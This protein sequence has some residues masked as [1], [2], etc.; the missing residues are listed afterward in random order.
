MRG[1]G[2]VARERAMAM[3]MAMAGRRTSVG[4]ERGHHETR[5]A[6]VG[7]ERPRGEWHKM[8]ALGHP[9]PGMY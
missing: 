4:G 7:K 9:R 3:A 5:R 1:G 6:K 2:G 8:E